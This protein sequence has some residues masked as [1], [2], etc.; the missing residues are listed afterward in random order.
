MILA[1]ALEV[2]ERA[3]RKGG[4][5]AVRV[6]LRA[7]APPPPGGQLASFGL[8]GALVDGLEP[9]ALVTATRVVDEA[10]AVLWE[11]EP[12]RVPG[13][14][15]AVICSSAEVVDGP[16]ERRALAE[17]TGAVAVD[18][19][20]GMLARSGRLAGV[21]RAVSDTPGRPVGALAGA[22]KEDGS[23]D[24]AVVAKAFATEP[25]VAARAARGARA[26]LASLS[27]AA[28]ALSGGPP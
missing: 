21:V 14:R 9:G 27:R 19:E 2:E 5:T 6:G 13:A 12:L 3:A 4:A 10:G 24:W 15:E 28:A 7:S 26:G 8:A 23:T 25:L 20:S 22:S 1:C 16:A 17:R 11:G 18:L